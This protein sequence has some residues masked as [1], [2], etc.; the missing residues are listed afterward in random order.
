[1]ELHDSLILERYRLA[2]DRQRYFTSVAR[3]AF[4]TYAKFVTGIAA[5][6]VTLLSARESLGLDPALIPA[7]L[8]LLAYLLAFLGIV[9]GIQ[10]A[11]ALVQW[12]RFHRLAARIDPETYP[13]PFAWWMLD[14]AYLLVIATSV[15]T[16]WRLLENVASALPVVTR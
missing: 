10:I 13:L 4:I 2:I 16:G 11:I 15:A 6:V 9:A 8:A 14:T 3:D 12:R 5:V 1:V 7:L